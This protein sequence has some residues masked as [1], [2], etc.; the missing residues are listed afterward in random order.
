MLAPDNP[1]SH[2]TRAERSARE[3]AGCTVRYPPPDSPD[4]NPIEP[5][6][7]E[8]EAMARKAAD[9]TA[10]AVKKLVRWHAS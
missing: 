3:E 6:V 5:A 2:K 1:A 8:P 10:D 7:A 9:R 4:F